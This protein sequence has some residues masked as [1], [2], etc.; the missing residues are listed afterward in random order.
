MKKQLQKFGSHYNNATG[1]IYLGL[2]GGVLAPVASFGAT[3]SEMV[4]APIS[5]MKKLIVAV[6]GLI[7]LLI[8]TVWI[9]LPLVV[10]MMINKHYKKKAEQ[11]DDVS[12]DMTKAMIIGGLGSVIAGFFIV[13]F[14]GML[15]FEAGTDLQTGIKAFYGDFLTGIRD[16]IASS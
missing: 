16:S 13:G 7:Y 4:T 11:Q 12:G 2:V 3:D 14:A 6:V 9:W 15:F 8:G 5:V 1:K 10:L